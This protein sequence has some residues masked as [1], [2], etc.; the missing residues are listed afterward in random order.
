MPGFFQK[1]AIALKPHFLRGYSSFLPELTHWLNS[2]KKEVFFLKKETDR[3][4]KIFRGQKTANF[5]FIE[6]ENIFKE[7]DFI[8]SLGGDGTLISLAAHAKREQTPIF[9]VNLG[10]LG[11]ITE[12][13]KKEIYEY[14]PHLFQGKLKT[15]KINLYSVNIYKNSKK[16]Q[17]HSFLN[18]AVLGRPDVARMFPLVL[19]CDGKEVY[20]FSGD[21][22]IISS[23]LGSTAYSLAAGGPI[24]HPKVQAIILSPICPHSLTNRPLIIPDNKEILLKTGKPMDTLLTV[25]GQRNFQI[26]KKD[27]ITIKKNRK[28]LNI[29]KNPDRNYFNTLKEKF[30]YGRR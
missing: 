20:N 17:S 9:G 1:T 12:F 29:V 5:K 15:E 10:R 7:S 27:F 22:I 30:F 14:L 11:F 26:E 2:Q 3:I 19:E 25:D 28:F 16:Y 24:V 13:Q 21:G 18:D 4:S 8:I 23:P 6:P